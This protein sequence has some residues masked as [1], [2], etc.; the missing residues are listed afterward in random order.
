MAYICTIHHS[1]EKFAFYDF[2]FAQAHELRIGG[3]NSECVFIFIAF[4][5][6]KVRFEFPSFFG[7]M[8]IIV[9]LSEIKPPLN[10]SRPQKTY[11]KVASSHTSCL[12]AH[13]DFF[14][15]LMKGIFD[16]YVLTL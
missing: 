3:L 13:R 2:L 4:C 11:C 9:I 7:H 6:K 12:E 5:P 14:R 10:I 15:L 8:A 1:L 16:P